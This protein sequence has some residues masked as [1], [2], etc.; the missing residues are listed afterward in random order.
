MRFPG[1]DFLF[2][3]LLATMML[4]AAVTLLPTF[5]IFKNLGWID[6]LLPLW[7]PSFFA[8]AFNVF[9]L[10]QFFKNVPME[11][12]DAAKIVGKKGWRSKG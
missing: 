9:L 1:R 5:L 11:L 4:P 7:V 3:V 12:E 2:A 6:S 10:R 8:G